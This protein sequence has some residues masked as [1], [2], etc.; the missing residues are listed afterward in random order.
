MTTLLCDTI[1]SQYYH[2]ILSKHQHK[3][4]KDKTALYWH[5]SEAGKT[6]ALNE[7]LENQELT[8]ILYFLYRELILE[9]C[10]G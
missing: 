10:R 2:F 4:Q 3:H 5:T 8:S 9:Q 7:K 6:P 1:L